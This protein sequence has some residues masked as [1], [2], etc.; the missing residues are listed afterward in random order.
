M[1]GERSKDGFYPLF[2]AAGGTMPLKAGKELGVTKQQQSTLIATVSMN[3]S[4]LHAKICERVDTIEKRRTVLEGR[5]DQLEQ[6]IREREARQRAGNI[7]LHR[8]L[9][10]L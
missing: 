5:Q 2:Q 6:E 7:E 9:E 3:N 1:A 4:E 10:E 8:E